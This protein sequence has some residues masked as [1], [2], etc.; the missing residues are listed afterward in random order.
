MGDTYVEKVF[1]ANKSFSTSTVR[2]LNWPFPDRHITMQCGDLLSV[3]VAPDADW[4]DDPLLRSLTWLQGL[5]L[6]SAYVA[7]KSR[8]EGR[9]NPMGILGSFMHGYRKMF[10]GGL[11]RKRHKSTHTVNVHVTLQVK[12]GDESG[13]VHKTRTTVS[14]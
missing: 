4:S 9:R 5:G 11:G 10:W 3:D 6:L 7:P 8:S 14:R 1:Q 2:N 12:G 13:Q